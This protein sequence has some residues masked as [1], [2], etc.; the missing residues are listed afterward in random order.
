M[1][2]RDDSGGLAP[3]T[4]AAIAAFAWA[5][6]CLPLAAQSIIP[7]AAV[8]CSGCAGQSESTVTVEGVVTQ[9]ATTPWGFTLQDDTDGIYIATDGRLG[10]TDVAPGDHLVVTGTPD[11]GEF[12]PIIKASKVIRRGRAPLPKPHPVAQSELSGGKLDNLY[13]EI[14]GTVRAVSLGYVSKSNP[15]AFLMLDTESRNSGSVE[16]VLSHFREDPIRYVDAVITARGVVGIVYNRKRQALGMNVFVDNPREMS[17]VKP[18]EADPF[19]M[20]LTPIGDLMAWGVNRD[21]SHRVRVRGTVTLHRIGEY[22]V[23]QDGPN[24]LRVETESHVSLRPGAQ[25]EATGF[26]SAGG[27][28]PNLRQAVIRQIGSGEE[29]PP[30]RRWPKQLLS[31]IDDDRLVTT[32]ATVLEAG[33]VARRT[34]ITL[35]DGG[36]QFLAEIPGPAERVPRLLRPGARVE[37]T[38]V[39]HILTDVSRKPKSIELLV[40]GPG[41]I[42]IVN[43]GPAITVTGIAWVGGT[44]AGAALV[45]VLWALTLR[46]RVREQTRW[47]QSSLDREHAIARIM[48]ERSAILERIGRNESLETILSEIVRFAAEF[49]PDCEPGILVSVDGETL[50]IGCC[51]GSGTAGGVVTAESNSGRIR[52]VLHFRRS[53]RLEIENEVV[54]V[55]RECAL[56][57]LEHRDL[58]ER[59]IEQSLSDP[60]TRL[61]NRR[62]LEE[63]FRLA[64]EEARREG[65]PLAVLALDL[66]GFKQVNDLFGHAVGDEVLREIS[67]RFSAAMRRSDM[68]A[69]VGGDEFFALLPRIGGRNRALEI[70]ERLLAIAAGEI[71]INGVRLSPSVS[72]GVALYPEDGDDAERLRNAADLRMYEHKMQSAHRMRAARVAAQAQPVSV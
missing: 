27:Y 51:E 64:L 3:G 48:A 19:G 21:W 25:V 71:E 13:V 31:G 57:A 40:R 1:Q 10:M 66:D 63:R 28:S 30:V 9:Y 68:L 8:H 12:A 26:V 2:S 56:L 14:R 37:I 47:I 44:V 29:P 6:A 53:P 16:V 72:V 52:A 41:D 58:H 43:A 59:L 60:L 17:V 33:N 50:E 11:A 32:S 35:E 36:I 5:T 20:K 24:A 69:R 22:V 65:Q 7:I 61:P 34:L 54:R 62:C 39:C 45:C 46:R 55:C 15:A 42:K 38:G 49:I 4:Y 23:L 70:A 18:P 67:R